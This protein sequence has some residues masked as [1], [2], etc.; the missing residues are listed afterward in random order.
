M[1]T[2]TKSIVLD[3]NIFINPKVRDLFGKSPTKALREFLKLASK[4]EV[5]KFYMPT[6]IFEELMDFI[7][8]DE[9]DS[10]LLLT[11]QQKSPKKHELRVPAFLLYELMKDIRK[12]VNKGLR[13]AETAVRNADQKNADETISN[14]RQKYRAALREGIIDSKEDA[15]LILLAKELNATLISTDKGVIN[16]AEKL[17]IKWTN[18][19]YIKEI[20][21]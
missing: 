11:I 18:A 19:T 2:K 15:D 13:V 20:I 4:N 21:S 7:E 9:I 16:W 8:K 12:R 10:K 14:L 5:I 6:S 1:S 17:G 3:T